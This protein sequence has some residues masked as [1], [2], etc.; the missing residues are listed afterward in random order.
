EF[1]P[2]VPFQVAGSK[3]G[4]GTG[5]FIAP[6]LIMTAAH[7]VI[8]AYP[9]RG[10][11]VTV[12]AI[13]KDRQ[14][15]TRVVTLLPE[16]DMAILAVTDSDFPPRTRYFN[17]GD[18]K[19]LTLGQQLLVVGYPMGDSD[20]KV[21]FIARQKSLRELVDFYGR[22]GFDALAVTDHAR[23]LHLPSLGLLYH[24]GTSAPYGEGDCRE[25]VRVQWVSRHSSLYG[26]VQPGDRLCAVLHTLPSGESEEYKI[27]N[28]GDVKVPWYGAKIPLSF[29]LE[30]LPVQKALQIRFWEAQRQQVHTVST[31]LRPVLS[32]AFQT[33][34]YPLEALDYETFGGLVVMP[35]RTMHLGKFRHLL[36]RLTPSQ[37][38]QEQLVI[39]YVVPN[40]VVSRAEVLG[41]GE[42]LEQVNGR[43]VH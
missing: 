33:V 5:F 39:S 37:R 6:T 41:G 27:D 4:R 10:V 14:F 31:V 18:V 3:Q 9:E 42:L 19:A 32:G 12:P 38:E 29:A 15:N 35:L 43:P 1:N 36:F 7:V 40:S 11:R 34:Y 23:V 25:G 2:L 8:K 28:V 22:R 21:S 13:G 20:V 24:N 16:I 17:R 26:I 30:L